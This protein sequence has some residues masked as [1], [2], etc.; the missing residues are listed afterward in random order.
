MNLKSPLLYLTFPLALAFGLIWFR[1]KKVHCDSGGKANKKNINITLNKKRADF[2]HSVSLP[3]GKSS[4]GNNNNDSVDFKFGKSAPID[5]T[6]NKISPIRNQSCDKQTVDAEVLNKKI[7]EADL[8]TLKLIEESSCESPNLPSSP[9]CRRRFSFTIR[10][11]EPPIV[12]K[13]SN[14]ADENSPQS[15][16]GDVP[17]TFSEDGKKSKKSPRPEKTENSIV[18][19]SPKK[20]EEKK[21]GELKIEAEDTATTANFQTNE[22]QPR[23]SPVSSP[24]LSLCSNKTAESGDSGKGSSP[25]HSEGEQLLASYDFEISQNHVSTLVGR[26]G[27]IVQF[28]KEQS[29]AS[30]LVRHHPTSRKHK[31]CTIEGTQK[32]VDEALI[33]LRAK[34]PARINLKR[35]EFVEET[36]KE[37]IV[38]TSTI[39]STLVQVC[40]PHI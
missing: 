13:A 29:G 31:L 18:K 26:N 11:Q 9:P 39:D 25:P 17:V 1:R 33:I 3:I 38:P 24:S 19:S 20:A 14:M 36:S 34:L 8:K 40:I 2:K 16:F 21:N 6:P 30:I 10:S 22:G 12:I 37:V 27:Q 23:N 5:I 4:T 15:S 28:V 7:Q 32:Q 35:Y